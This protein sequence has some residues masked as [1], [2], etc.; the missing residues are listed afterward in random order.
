MEW[1]LEEEI[2]LLREEMMKAATEKGL[3]AA[4]TIEFSRRLDNLM[5]Q[6]AGLKKG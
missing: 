5:D 6:Y 2:E 4:E 1:T 3:T